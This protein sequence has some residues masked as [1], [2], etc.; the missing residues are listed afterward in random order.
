MHVEAFPGFFF[1][2]LLLPIAIAF[3]SHRRLSSQT[4]LQSYR[5]LLECNETYRSFEGIGDIVVSTLPNGREVFLPTA[6]PSL[7]SEQL[8]ERRKEKKAAAI[9]MRQ[10]IANTQIDLQP[11]FEALKPSFTEDK[12]DVLQ[13]HSDFVRALTERD[14][15]LMASLWSDVNTTLCLRYEPRSGSRSSIY[16]SSGFGDILQSWQQFFSETKRP[17]S[18][19][20]AEVQLFFY[21]DMAVVTSKLTERVK[22]EGKVKSAESFNT[23]VLQKSSASGRYLLVSYSSSPVPSDTASAAN[24]KLRLTYRDPSKSTGSKSRDSN[25]AVVLQRM[26]GG[27]VYSPNQEDDD[28]EDEDEEDEDEQEVEVVEIEDGK[29]VHVPI[30]ATLCNQVCIGESEEA[31]TMQELMN[32]RIKNTIRQAV[33]KFVSLAT[34]LLYFILTWY[35]IICRRRMGREDQRRTL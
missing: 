22:G 9:R 16:F 17:S 29:L 34:N 35:C 3:T 25:P 6:L 14:L 13:A 24:T 4:I 15:V 28:E 27:K 1:L 23:F 20:V 32:S 30:P 11:Y 2:A 31:S 12:C 5:S 21:G 10:A 19:D 26:F 18:I 8:W 33:T 7:S